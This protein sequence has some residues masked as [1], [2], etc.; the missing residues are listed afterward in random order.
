MYRYLLSHT[1]PGLILGIEIILA[2]YWFSDLPVKA[3]I[4][5]G[6]KQH[7]SVIILIGYAISTLMGFIVDGIH[8]FFFEDL[9]DI[10]IL[11][12]F[13]SLFARSK[14]NNFLYKLYPLT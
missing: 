14:L 11:V 9:L 3:C 2:I 8:H 13:K 10:K 7:A 12:Y 6:F 5:T 4:E 1:F